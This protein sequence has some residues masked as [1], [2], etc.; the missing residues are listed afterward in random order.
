MLRV[1]CTNLK[2]L[3]LDE[4]GSIVAMSPDF[5]FG[6]EEGRL[7]A[8]ARFEALAEA[9]NTARAVTGEDVCQAGVPFARAA[10]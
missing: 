5:R 7:A 3:L 1:A 10:P 8:I 9:Y 2:A 6:D 4:E